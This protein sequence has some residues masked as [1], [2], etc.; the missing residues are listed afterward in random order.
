LGETIFRQCAS[1]LLFLIARDLH[2]QIQ[3]ISTEEEK[4]RVLT[5][6][7]SHLQWSCTKDKKTFVI[8][9]LTA[10][11]KSSHYSMHAIGGYCKWVSGF[12]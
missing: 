12:F 1:A 8:N 3:L 6:Q 7:E 2:H 5:R 4:S 10:S 9:Q 11:K